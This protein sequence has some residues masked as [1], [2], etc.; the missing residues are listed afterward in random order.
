[1]IPTS[2]KD[3][4]SNPLEKFEL[5]IK[6]MMEL[7]MMQRMNENDVIVTKY[8]DDAEFQKVV[9][10]LLAKEIYTSINDALQKGE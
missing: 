1:M 4:N 3:G 2:N 5:G 7:M 10:P 6:K 8:M 9:L